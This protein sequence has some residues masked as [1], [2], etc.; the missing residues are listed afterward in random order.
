M[1]LKQVGEWR[2]PQLDMASRRRGSESN[3]R[4][5]VREY[6][7]V[8]GYAFLLREKGLSYQE[9]ANTLNEEGHT[10]RRSKPFKKMTV[11]RLLER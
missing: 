11:K 3:L 2:N 8:K 6:R 5:A 4:E 7:T 1:K 9:I 10:T